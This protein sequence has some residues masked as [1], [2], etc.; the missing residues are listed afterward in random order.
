M[1]A[2]M[3]LRGVGVA[4]V[5]AGLVA[6]MATGAMAASPV[7]L[8]IAEKAGGA[9]KSGGLSG[10]CK[11][12]YTKVALPSEEAEQQKL[13]SILPYVK[14]APSGVGGKPTIQFSGV[15]VQVVNGEGKTKSTNGEGNV[16]VG[17]DEN[18]GLHEQTGSHNLI[19]GEEQT[20]TSFGGL[21]AG[22]MN[23]IE[24]PFASVAGG[25]SNRADGG[26]APS[27]TGGRN[28]EASGE[29]ASVSGG[30]HNS[31][32]GGYASITGGEENRASGRW[33]SVTGGELNKATGDRSSVT[34]GDRNTA[35]GTL[36]SVTGGDFNEATSGQSSVTGG[37]SNIAGGDGFNTVVGGQ[38]NVAKGIF[39]AL[40]GGEHVTWGEGLRGHTLPE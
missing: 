35:S 7:Y 28:N 26:S 18:E 8:C 32:G 2:F 37:D 21:A 40:L 34:G 23:R 14:Y 16:V 30:Y 38:F 5:A 39:N 19:L 1:R 15:N 6:V 17:Y 3:A 29:Y 13:L 22:D 24:S 31:A 25:Y 27:V 11:A 12:K 9:V 33:A 36:S 10:S 20:F 4:S